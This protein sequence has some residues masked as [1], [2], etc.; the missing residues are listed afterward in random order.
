MEE[1]IPN[2]EISSLESTLREVSKRITFH[3]FHQL[4]MAAL[5]KI[6]GSMREDRNYKSRKRH[7]IKMFINQQASIKQCNI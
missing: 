7:K 3:L 1:F 6:Q 2:L 4:F 5:M